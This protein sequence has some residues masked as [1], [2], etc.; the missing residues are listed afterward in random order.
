MVEINQFNNLFKNNSISRVLTSTKIKKN[1][2]VSHSIKELSETFQETSTKFKAYSK[3]TF[4]NSDEYFEEVPTH[5]NDFDK[6]SLIE[7]GI[8]S[9]SRSDVKKIIGKN[10]MYSYDKNYETAKLI[11]N[12]KNTEFDDSLSKLRIEYFEHNSLKIN[13]SN[14][15]KKRKSKIYNFNPKI[16]G[17]RYLN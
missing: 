3:E 1:D 10:E 5:L 4:Y 15:Q 9:L 7:N 8:K 16:H 12:K 14:K 13:D 17:I 11:V 6:N 2:A